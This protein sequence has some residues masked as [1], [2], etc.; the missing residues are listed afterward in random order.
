MS[1]KSDTKIIGMHQFKKRDHGL[2]VKLGAFVPEAAPAEI[3]QGHKWHM[4]VE[5]NNALQEAAKQKVNPVQK[6]A[7]DLALKKMGKN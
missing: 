5:F 1:D 6:A 3:A 4:M 7:I 2:Y